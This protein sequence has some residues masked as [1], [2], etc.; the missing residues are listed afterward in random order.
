MPA[1]PRSA[2]VLH[3][4]WKSSAPGRGLSANSTSAQRRYAVRKPE[5]T[6]DGSLSVDVT[7]AWVSAML[8]VVSAKP[9]GS[10]FSSVTNRRFCAEVIEGEIG[11]RWSRKTRSIRCGR[12]ATTAHNRAIA[13]GNVLETMLTVFRLQSAIGSGSSH[14]TIPDCTTNNGR[15]SRLAKEDMVVRSSC[16]GCPGPRPGAST[17]KCGHSGDSALNKL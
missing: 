12:E 6:A 13:T 10:A 4:S 11:A 17:L 3:A 7:H 2:I 5:S 8:R 15:P 16:R 9:G 1:P 14:V